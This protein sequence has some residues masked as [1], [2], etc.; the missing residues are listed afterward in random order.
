M[1]TDVTPE[2][3]LGRWSRE[4]DNLYAPSEDAPEVVGWGFTIDGRSWKVDPSWTQ[5]DCMRALQRAFGQRVPV[6]HVRWPD[7]ELMADRI[8]EG[9]V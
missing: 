1:D 7:E 9:R 5:K 8:Q 4:D 2:M 6:I 3:K